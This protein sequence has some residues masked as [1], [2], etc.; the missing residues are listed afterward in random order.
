MFLDFVPEHSALGAILTIHVIDQLEQCEYARSESK[1]ALCTRRM[2]IASL[3]V[4]LSILV[5]NGVV[6]AAQVGLMSIQKLPE[7]F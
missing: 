4:R 2:S 5:R 1:H 6:A 3:P 7:S